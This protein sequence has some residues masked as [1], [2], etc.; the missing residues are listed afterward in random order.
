MSIIAIEIIIVLPLFTN[1]EDVA[2]PLW[3][4]SL[5]CVQGK[6]YKN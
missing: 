5:K 3:N 2:D 6:F 1:Y 4:K